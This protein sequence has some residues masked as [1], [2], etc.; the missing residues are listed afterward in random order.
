MPKFQYIGEPFSRENPGTICEFM[1]YDAVE[2]RAKS[3]NDWQELPN[4]Y[5]PQKVDAIKEKVKKHDT[6]IAN[7]AIATS[8]EK[9]MLQPNEDK[10]KPLPAFTK[11][12]AV[13][14]TLSPEHLAKLKAGREA[15]RAA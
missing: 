6:V 15:K 9:P 13:K 7:E 3:N 2:M 14:R 1:E 4:D 12:Q 11:E 5:V 8:V 10:P